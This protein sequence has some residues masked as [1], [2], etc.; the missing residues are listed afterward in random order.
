MIIGKS[1]IAARANSGALDSGASF[2]RL[3]LR[4]KDG[5]DIVVSLR[6]RTNLVGSADGCRVRLRSAE[7]APLHAVITRDPNGLQ[8]RRLDPE[9]RL[10][11]NREPIEVGYLRDGDKIRV[12]PISMRLATN[13]VPVD[14]TALLEDFAEHVKRRLEHD[15]AEPFA[16]DSELTDPKGDS[17]SP[18]K[19]SETVHRWQQLAEQLE[20]QEQLLLQVEKDLTTDASSS[21]PGVHKQVQQLSELHDRI[22]NEIAVL[23]LRLRPK[24]LSVIETKPTG[25]S[26]ESP[27][28]SAEQHDNP[29]RRST[30]VL[31][32]TSSHE[33]GTVVVDGYTCDECCGVVFAKRPLKWY[34]LPLWFCFMRGVRCTNCDHQTLQFATRI[35]LLD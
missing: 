29:A 26:Q 11:L 18:A 22:R 14:P 16:I 28:K 17:D 15:S 20:Q 33:P 24:P 30:V 3:I 32:G 9:G 25:S 12:G 19:V 34:E 10:E 1:L 23:R 5:H 27:K 7:I 35:S 6:H 13:V 2:A 4:K 8:I 21:D 31:N